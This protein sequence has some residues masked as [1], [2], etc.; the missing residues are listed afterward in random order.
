MASTRKQKRREGLAKS[1]DE[2]FGTGN[3]A[4]RGLRAANRKVEQRK[5]AQSRR[6][7]SDAK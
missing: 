5:R 1:A 4:S 6:G 7:R 3:A 2:W